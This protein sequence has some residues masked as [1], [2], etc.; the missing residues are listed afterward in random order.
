[1]LE[2][3]KLSV[4]YG[5]SK[6]VHEVSFKITEE[7][8]FITLLGGNGAGKTSILKAISGLVKH[9]GSILANGVNITKSPPWEIVEMG[10][11]HVPQNRLMFPEMTVQENLELG[12][13]TYATRKEVRDRVKGIIAQFPIM[14]P[15]IKK[16]AG[17]LSGGQQQI[18]AIA[19]A[20]MSKPKLL[21]LDEPTLGLAPVM[22]EKIIQIIQELNRNGLAILLVEQNVAVALTL[23]Q[24]AYVIEG[25]RLKRQG[26]AKELMNDDQVRKA[27]LGI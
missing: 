5:A 6:V 4:F 11:A 8:N 23:A 12:A 18:V 20:L 16:K 2:V 19:R 17:L 14:E 1:M 9:D 27:Y 13:F 24:R 25:G 10:I 22:I 15:F 26:L 7:E 21:L 3:T